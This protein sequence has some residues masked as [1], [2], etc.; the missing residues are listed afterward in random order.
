MLRSIVPSLLALA[1]VA[2]AVP[3]LGA[4]PPSAQNPPPRW[5]ATCGSPAANGDL[6]AVGTVQV[7][8]DSG[9]EPES[10]SPLGS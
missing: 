5:P 4:A 6:A 10:A 3:G 8:G 7:H 1:F 9:C 2:A